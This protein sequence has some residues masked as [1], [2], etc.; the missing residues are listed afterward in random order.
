MGLVCGIVRESG[1][2]ADF[3]RPPWALLSL[4]SRVGAGLASIVLR[5]PATRS[6]TWPGRRSVLSATE[7]LSWTPHGPGCSCAIKPGL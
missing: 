1:D 2:V 7:M 6:V 3:G 4:P 5:P